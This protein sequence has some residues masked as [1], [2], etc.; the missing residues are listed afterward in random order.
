ML[1]A[2]ALRAELEIMRAQSAHPFN[3]EMTDLVCEYEPKRHGLLMLLIAL[4]QCDCEEIEREA[5]QDA[6]LPNTR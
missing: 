2:E 1:R 5:V 4:T 6:R 3:R